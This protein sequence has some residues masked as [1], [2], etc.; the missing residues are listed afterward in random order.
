MIIQNGFLYLDKE[1]VIEMLNNN[2]DVKSREIDNKLV[3]VVNNYFNRLSVK[4]EKWLLEK[5]KYIMRHNPNYFK[6]NKLSVEL[7][8][9]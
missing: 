4:Q 1:D 6:Y 9:E 3:S 2:T 5:L 7:E 8:K